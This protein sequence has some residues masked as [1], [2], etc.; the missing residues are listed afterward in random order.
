MGGHLS[1]VHCILKEGW[2]LSHL[3]VSVSYLA[4]HGGV[5]YWYWWVGIG[6]L[7]LVGYWVIVQFNG[8]CCQQ[9]AGLGFTLV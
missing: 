8:P 7:V 4:G 5:G 6:V 9:V 2:E 1:L 3:K